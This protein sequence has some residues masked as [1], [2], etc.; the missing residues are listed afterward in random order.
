MTKS[1]VKFRQIPGF[2]IGGR[3]LASII[4]AA[5][6]LL[7]GSAT[8][9]R[10]LTFDL[11]AA[12]S[13]AWSQALYF[14]AGPMRLTV[15]AKDTSN[16]QTAKVQTWAGLGLGVRSVRDCTVGGLCVGTDSQIDANLRRDIAVLTFDRPVTVTGLTLVG[17]SGPETF[18]FY[19]NGVKSGQYP[20]TPVTQLFSALGTDF[21]IGAGVTGRV[22]CA[23]VKVHGQRQCPL[24]HTYSS[25]YLT[26]L[27]VELA[28]VPAPAGVGMLASGIG[29]LAMARRRKTA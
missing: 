19:V 22:I 4:A 26:S 13:G 27:T 18:D 23:P 28:S 3:G 29:A 7:S 15:T 2:R 11:A 25:F 21:G 12:D 8:S 20:A 10:T 9:A 6:W 24:V 14:S 17:A 5:A 16:R 1:H